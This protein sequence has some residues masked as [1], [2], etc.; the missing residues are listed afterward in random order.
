[1]DTNKEIRDKLA[2][3]IIRYRDAHDY[4]QTKFAELAG[5]SRVYVGE[6]ETSYN[7][8]RQ[9]RLDTIMKIEKILTPWEDA[10]LSAE[11]Q[12]A[13]KINE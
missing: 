10:Q 8:K 6:I 13:Q 3:R 1:L 4:S 5:V 9:I 11:M 2:L 12:Q 7:M